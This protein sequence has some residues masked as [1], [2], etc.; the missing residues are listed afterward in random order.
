[1]ATGKSLPPGAN[2]AVNNN[3][4]RVKPAPPT[5]TVIAAND[6]IRDKDRAKEDRT[7]PALPGTKKRRNPPNPVKPLLDRR[8]QIINLNK[9]ALNIK[10]KE[11]DPKEEAEVEAVDAEAKVV[12]A[13][14]KTKVVKTKP[15]E[16]A[17]AEIVK[18]VVKVPETNKD[19]VANKDKAL[20]AK[21]AGV[22]EPKVRR[23]V[24]VTALK[25]RE[26]PS[27]KVLAAVL[28]V[29]PV[30]RPRWNSHLI[31]SWRIVRFSISLFADIFPKET[32]LPILS[33]WTIC[34]KLPR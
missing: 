7:R 11:V 26:D 21:E 6:R 25:A 15:E 29:A 18:D 12:G 14:M 34:C 28:K 10:I 20:V 31:S 17:D 13:E 5:T 23:D 22:E 1:M 16:G 33:R 2:A 3:P 19:K 30:K 27:L 9:E 32:L 24:K 8:N 4:N